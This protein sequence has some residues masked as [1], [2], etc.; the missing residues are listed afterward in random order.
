MGLSVRWRRKVK[1]TFS[2]T[3]HRSWSR[4]FTLVSTSTLGQ[5]IY[6][7]TFFA[8]SRHGH[9]LTH[10]S[11]KEPSGN[12][13]ARKVTPGASAQARPPGMRTVHRSVQA[14]V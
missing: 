2:P 8:P 14:V 12:S 1:C 7:G 5:K 13:A 10:R 9:L 4:D 11:E 6:P 3:S